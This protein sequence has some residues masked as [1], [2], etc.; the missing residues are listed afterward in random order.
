MPRV[1]ARNST[2]KRVGTV[3]CPFTGIVSDVFEARRGL[4]GEG[5][6]YYRNPEAGAIQLGRGGQ[7]WFRQQAEAGKL[8][9][10]GG[11]QPP[12][13]RE[14]VPPE[15]VGSKETAGEPAP[16]PQPEPA[17]EPQPARVETLADR[18]VAGLGAAR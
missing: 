5:L 11:Y 12:W 6:L 13:A 4:Y 10:E 14:A 17:R 16:E 9:F 3:P 8:R 18:L 15:P 1:K 7:D 2:K